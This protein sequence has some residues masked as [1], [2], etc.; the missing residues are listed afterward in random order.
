MS[1]SNFLTNL[2]FNI[3]HCKLFAAISIQLVRMVRVIIML[4]R[5][6]STDS[7]E[8][9]VVSLITAPPSFLICAKKF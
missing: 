7:N 9:V 6:F 8:A 3:H 4:A 1:E 2:N 5:F